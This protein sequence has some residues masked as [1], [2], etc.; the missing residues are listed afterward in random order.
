MCACLLVEE[1]GGYERGGE[2]ATHLLP[3]LL[4]L[5]PAVALLSALAIGALPWAQ[6]ALGVVLVLVPV[7]DS[8]LH[9]A[10]LLCTVGRYHSRQ[11]DTDSFSARG[12][13]WRR[14]LGYASLTS[15]SPISASPL[16][17]LHLLLRVPMIPDRTVDAGA[18][19]APLLRRLRGMQHTLLVVSPFLLVPATCTVMIVRAVER[20]Q[21]GEAPER[22]GAAWM[23]ALHFL[24]PHHRA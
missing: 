10:A 4:Q 15:A 1:E 18:A 6:H 16:V 22:F 8:L 3:L 5:P 12:C 11:A 23:P 13:G 19:G 20:M 14:S 17:P 21:R 2:G 9:E 7:S 24:F